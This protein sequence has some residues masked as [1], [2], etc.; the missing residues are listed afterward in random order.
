MSQTMEQPN[1][2]RMGNHPPQYGY[3]LNAPYTA[4]PNIPQM[5]PQ[6]NV[7]GQPI[8]QDMAFQYGQQVEKE[9]EKTYN[10]CCKM[11]SD[12]FVFVL[13]SKYWKT[14]STTEF[15]KVCSYIQVKVLLCR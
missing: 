8:V 2:D 3:N 6:F 4:A 7:L 9:T 11:K 15:G 13:A 5:P 10:K 12:S 1:F 14:S